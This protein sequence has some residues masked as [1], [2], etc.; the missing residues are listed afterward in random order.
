MAELH[1]IRAKRK[2]NGMSQGLTRRIFLAAAP[3]SAASTL[4]STPAFAVDECAVENYEDNWRTSITAPYATNEAGAPGL[5]AEG[6]SIIHKF[7]Y[8][9]L[10]RSEKVATSRDLGFSL[11]N[12]LVGDK[13]VF[14]A[15][16]VSPLAYV[17][18]AVVTARYGQFDLFYWP[19]WNSSGGVGNNRRAFRDVPGIYFQV[20]ASNGQTLRFE[21]EL[22][23]V[24]NGPF[25]YSTDDMPSAQFYMEAEFKIRDSAIS[26]Q[27]AYVLRK[28]GTLT[29]ETGI[30]AARGQRLVLTRQEVSGHAVDSLYQRTINDFSDGMANPYS[31]IC[32]S[33]NCFLTTAC[34]TV[35][36]RPDNGL[37]LTTLRRFRDGWLARQPFG[38]AEIVRYYEIAPH[39]SQSLMRS[40]EGRK[41]LRR[42]YWRTILPCVVT[43]RLGLPSLSYRL[44]KKMMTS[45]ER[46]FS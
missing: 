41:V 7:Q 26:N 4:C 13:I 32:G 24:A 2:G 40:A 42:L 20:T 5:D 44:Y 8:G 29:V 43:I 38:A 25:A 23:R 17:D 39:I 14:S 6:L 10:D 15:L 3:A 37:E 11:E 34:C 28:S 46:S 21:G 45:L 16:T 9:R 27:L 1:N 36:G 33:N 30:L 18:R 22:K 19:A 35:L 31:M 12:E